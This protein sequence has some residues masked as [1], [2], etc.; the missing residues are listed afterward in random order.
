MA[1]VQEHEI[2]ATT[3]SVLSRILYA[4]LRRKVADGG[5]CRDSTLRSIEISAPPVVSVR[6]KSK[7][8]AA[9]QND[10]AEGRRVT[11]KKAVQKSVAL[12]YSVKLPLIGFLA[13]KEVG[14]GESEEGRGW[15]TGACQA[16]AF[17]IDIAANGESARD[18]HS[19]QGGYPWEERRRNMLAVCRRPE[20]AGTL[21]WRRYTIALRR[22]LAK[23]EA[24]QDDK[25]MLPRDRHRENGDVDIHALS[26]LHKK[27]AREAGFEQDVA[28]LDM[29]I[30]GSTRKETDQEKARR[31]SRKWLS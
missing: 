15:R 1:G 17:L 22:V 23:E 4:G 26:M 21:G 18:I 14:V 13:E 7:K 24:C 5:P 11:R 8:R 28:T 9:R 29:R 25:K 20:K 31:N 10:S 16:Q 12:G 19:V 3:S 30:A 27:I 6:R 2:I